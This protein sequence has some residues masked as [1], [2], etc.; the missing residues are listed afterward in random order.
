MIEQK[1]MREIKALPK[2]GQNLVTLI[3]IENGESS[4]PVERKSV[5]TSSSLETPPSSAETLSFAIPILSLDPTAHRPATPPKVIEV[6]DLTRLGDGYQPRTP[7]ERNSP[8]PETP[9]KRRIATA[10]T[11]PRRKSAQRNR[12]V[13]PV[14]PTS[15]RRIQTVLTSLGGWKRPLVLLEDDSPS[16][17]RKTPQ[18]A[19]ERR[20]TFGQGA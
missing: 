13:D 9:T 15:N 8:T 5:E 17:K 7:P 3:K 14:T 11:T 1:S 20:A 2:D 10:T 12:V 19:K 4:R 18:K 6:I 16:K